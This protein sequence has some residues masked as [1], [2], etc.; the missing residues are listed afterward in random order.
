MCPA[1]LEGEHQ[2][3]VCR[4]DG[5]QVEQHRLERQDERAEGA[6]KQQVGED[7]DGEHEP[8]EGAIGRVDEVDA[9]GRRCR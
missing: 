8:G 3:A 1:V 4:A 9:E 6:Q 7:E 2:H 5:E